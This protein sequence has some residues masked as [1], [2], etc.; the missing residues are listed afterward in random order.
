MALNRFMHSR[1]RYKDTPPDFAQLAAKYPSFKEHVT[2]NLNGKV[3]LDF[4]NPEA[5]RALT[6]TLLKEDFGIDLDVPLDRLVPTVPLRLN[7]IHW[8]EDLIQEGGTYKGPHVNGIDIGTGASCIY[9]LLGVVLDDWQFVATES[10]PVNIKYARENVARNDKDSKIRVYETDDDNIL[11]KLLDEDPKKSFTFCMCNPPFYGSPL[12]AQGLVSRTSD[13]P[14]PKSVSTAADSESITEG[15]EVAF[16]MKIIA[17]SLKYKERVRWYTSML[18]RKKSLVPLKAEL[19]KHQVTNVTT[20]EFCQGKTLRWGIAWTFSEDVSSLPM[21][22]LRKFQKEK[23]KPPMVFTVPEAFVRNAVERLSITQAVQSKRHA[24][25]LLAVQKEVEKM[26]T[27]LQIQYKLLNNKGFILLELTAFS[28]TWSNQRKRRREASL[29][30]KEEMEK[31][32]RMDAGMGTDQ[33]GGFESVG[34][35]VNGKV[36]KTNDGGEQQ[37]CATKEHDQNGSSVPGSSDT[38]KSVEA[39]QT[40]AGKRDDIKQ[41]GELSDQS[42]EVDRSTGS[43]GSEVPVHSTEQDSACTSTAQ[44]ST[45]VDPGNSQDSASGMDCTASSE[46]KSTQGDASGVPDPAPSSVQS[47]QRQESTGDSGGSDTDS[48]LLKCT[49]TIKNVNKEVVMEMRFIEGKGRDLLNQ[50]AQ[51]FKN[52]FP[53]RIQLSPT[54]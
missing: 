31:K 41:Y 33:P 4:K 39:E 15:G 14:D 46:N 2:I 7:Y 38:D 1:N 51:Y 54:R 6:C 50:V 11:S 22:P 26:M 48:P 27:E 49:V 3:C 10:D 53:K 16:V 24:V 34:K 37:S 35:E 43:S 8:I 17:D 9:P 23:E 52:Q 12:E 29:R 21:S 30:M 36:D 20:T 28:N 42:H 32:A 40:D 25:R 18:G 13:R 5:L 44:T 47:Y 19:Q 45:K